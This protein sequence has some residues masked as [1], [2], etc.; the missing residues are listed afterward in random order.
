MG[1]QDSTFDTLL[2]GKALRHELTAL[3]QDTSDAKLRKAALVLLKERF[4]D[5]RLCVKAD[6]DAG[7]WD[8]VRAAQALSHIQD[9]LI[10]VLYDFAT[11]HVYY[12]QNPTT[13]ER[14]AIVATG[15]YGRGMLAPGSDVDLLFVRPFK[16]TAWGESVIEFILHMLWDLGLK[17]GHATRS[18]TE[19][20]RLSR[21]DITIR[22][23]LLEARYLWADRELYD[24]LRRKFWSDVAAKSGQE[25]VQSKLAERDQRHLHQGESRY[26]VEPNIKEGKGGLR[27]LQTLYWIGKYLYRV[28]DAADL[29]E[30]GVF[31][32]EEYKTFQHAEAFLWNVRV[33]LHYLVGRAE[34]RLSFDS[35][36]ELAER[37]GFKGESQRRAV[38]AFMRAYFLV[39]KDVGDLT[40]IFCAALEMQNR[41]PKPSLAR[42]LPSFLKPRT[43]AEDFYVD[44]GRLNA[45]PGIFKRDPVNLIRIFH[46]ADEKGTDI[47]PDALRTITRSLALIT[48][49][50]RESREANR[51]FLET[52]SSRRNPERALRWMNEA[53]VLGRFMPEF[54]HAIGLMQFNMYH[55]Y[56]VDEHLLRAV[57]NVAAIERGER[58]EEHPLATELIK[59]IAAR[60]VLYVALLL[61]DIAKGLGGNHSL[62]GA[63]IA[64]NSV[65]PRLGLSPA[66]TDT[67]A[68]LVKNHLLMSDVAQRRDISDPKTVR[69]FVAEVQTPDKL[70]LLLVLTVCDIRAVGPG[71]WNGWKGQLLRELYHEAETVMSGADAIPARTARVAAAKATLAG[72]IAN[73]PEVARER[74]LTRHYDA[75]WLAFDAHEHEWHARFTAAADARGELLALISESN[76]FRSVTEVVIY[77]PD[78]PGLFSKLA[79]AIAIS[80]GSIVD[81]KAFTTTDGFALDVFSVQDSDGGPFG[82]AARVERLRQTIVKTLSGE[83]RP[84]SVFANRPPKKRSRAFVVEARANFDNEASNKATVLEVEGLDRPGLLY[85][86][87]QAIFESGLSISSAIIATYGE[88]ASDVFYVRDGYGHKVTHPERLKAIHARLIKALEG[89]P[90]EVM[91]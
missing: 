29:V 9:T 78:H 87:T 50:L 81:A 25:F 89:E 52:L 84:R 49:E 11:K 70:R 35:Q 40:R 75:Y 19:C 65:C 76:D 38:E 4:A 13:A 37:L 5:A 51:L 18:L 41:K 7:R 30:H 21:Q 10:Q 53:G 24:E 64:T 60:E 77:T 71:V 48:P 3:A 1:Y 28:E 80:G 56:T 63:E 83:I 27:D 82:D 72:R 46:L 57:G 32:R 58:A 45:N 66:D 23:A 69:D 44:N 62:V 55:H 16:E 88:R 14:I 54:D 26:L 36:P 79:G 34:E 90:A 61:H 33:H 15:G 31:T 67:V 74:A 6:V 8:G 86:V 59:R 17:V 47:H 22:T 43:G 42:L 68:W 12:A 91:A 20:I 39:A 85:D 73:L 2:D